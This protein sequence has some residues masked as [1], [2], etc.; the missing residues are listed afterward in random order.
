MPSVAQPDSEINILSI[1]SVCKQRLV[2]ADRVKYDVGIA[3]F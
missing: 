3:P 2:A 1:T